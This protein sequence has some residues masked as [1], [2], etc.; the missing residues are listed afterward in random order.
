LP[1][2]WSPYTHPEGQL[3]FHRDS[4]LKITT[5]AYLY[6][7]EILNKVLLWAKEI[8]AIFEEKSIPFSDSIELYILIEEA[9]CAYYLIDHA[10]KSQFW[11]ESLQN[12]QLGIPD[13]DSPSHLNL[14]L[15]YLYWVHIEHFPMHF[16]GF[17][18][19]VV[20]SLLYVFT[21]GLTDQITSQTSTFYYTQTEC[22]KFIKILKLARQNSADGHQICVIARLWRSVCDNRFQTHYGQETSRLGRN[23]AILY[24]SPVP[25]RISS[26]ARC[27]TFNASDVY[28]ARLND[29]FVDHLVYFSQ[30][31]PFIRR[32][33]QG[34]KRSFWTAF[35]ILAYV[36][37]GATP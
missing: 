9:G 28:L 3:Y 34:W 7:P 1:P 20:D 5:D 11:L 15:E 35:A 24:D 22:E 8:E 25:S 18:V 32:C 27:L 36:L 4:A 6:S 12:D 33:M 26:V 23:Q 10:S 37:Y 14:Y 19:E 2:Q 21:H 29:L 31:Q 17:P 16:G 30:W 13:V